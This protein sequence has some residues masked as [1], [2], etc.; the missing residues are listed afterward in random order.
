[1]VCIE[2]YEFI[3]LKKQNIPENDSAII[4]L[5]TPYSI[6]AENSFFDIV[7]SFIFKFGIKLISD[8]FF[9]FKGFWAHEMTYSDNDY[10]DAGMNYIKGKIFTIEKDNFVCKF[11]FISNENNFDKYINEVDQIFNSIEFL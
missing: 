3:S 6:T 5:V 10:L 2:Y 11:E 9:T 8:N 4:Y 7:R 1:M